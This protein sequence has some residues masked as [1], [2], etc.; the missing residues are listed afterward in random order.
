[1]NTR[2]AIRYSSALL[3]ANHSKAT[4]KWGGDPQIECNIVNCSS[5]GVGVIILP[6]QPLLEFPK[7]NDTIL[8]KMLAAK[9]WFTGTCIYTSLDDRSIAIGI[10]FPNQYEQDH[11]QHLLYKALK[12]CDHLG[13]D[14]NK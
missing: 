9:R 10:Y 11:I 8:V 4:I 2:K 1:M 12:E 13:G 6:L 5:Q 3:P 14:V 7:E